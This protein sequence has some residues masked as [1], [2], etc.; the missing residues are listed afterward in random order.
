[1]RLIPDVV[2]DSKIPAALKPPG[3]CLLRGLLFTVA[4]MDREGKATDS[5]E[6]HI[7]IAA[8]K[9]RVDVVRDY[10]CLQFSFLA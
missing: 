3:F 1:M 4:L 6:G 5:R 2:Q 8:H 7:R 10:A 9:I